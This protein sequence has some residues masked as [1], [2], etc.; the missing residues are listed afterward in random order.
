MIGAAITVE[1]A[2]DG[3]TAYVLSSGRIIDKRHFPDKEKAKTWAKSRVLEIFPE[4]KT[5]REQIE[6][7]GYAV[8]VRPAPRDGEVGWYAFALLGG[9]I[10]S[11]GYGT[12]E[13]DALH[14]LVGEL[15]LL[16][17]A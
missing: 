1:R 4:L 14:S 3:F 15:G 7:A 13:L 6:S 10:V 16:S 2:H 5:P 17:G 12:T 11:T 9:R 8:E